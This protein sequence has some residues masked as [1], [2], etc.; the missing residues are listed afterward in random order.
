MLISEFLLFNQ[1]YLKVNMLNLL[2]DHVD[3]NYDNE[4]FIR[5]NLKLLI[6]NNYHKI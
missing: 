1:I 5:L 6:I 2:M 3:Y 4:Y